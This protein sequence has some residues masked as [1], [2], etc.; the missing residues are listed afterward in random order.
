MNCQLPHDSYINFEDMIALYIQKKLKREYEQKR[1]PCGELLEIRT[2]FFL[3]SK[4]SRRTM[5]KRAKKYK[6]CY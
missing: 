3:I 1:Q 6:E 5:S 4:K 2:H